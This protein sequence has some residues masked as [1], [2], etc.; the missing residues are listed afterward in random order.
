MQ[1]RK[2]LHQSTPFSHWGDALG[3]MHEWGH[4][5]GGFS[6]AGGLYSIVHAVF[7]TQTMLC[8]D[9]RNVDMITI[10]RATQLYRLVFFFP[11]SRP[12]SGL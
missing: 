10:I 6:P 11:L 7:L 9:G 3:S 1:T 12:Q 2:L 8:K 5:D 4:S